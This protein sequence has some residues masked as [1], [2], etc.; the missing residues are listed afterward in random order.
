MTTGKMLGFANR[1]HWKDTVRPEEEEGLSF[2]LQVDW[3]AAEA[4]FVF[5]SAILM[6]HLWPVPSASFF[7]T[8]ELQVPVTAMSSPLNF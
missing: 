5:T 6:V 3:L 8:S 1:G 2:L 4:W 7:T